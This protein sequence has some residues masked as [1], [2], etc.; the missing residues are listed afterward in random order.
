M[1]RWDEI[2]VQDVDDAELTLYPVPHLVESQDSSDDEEDEGFHSIKM[3]DGEEEEEVVVFEDLTATPK[4][5][6]TWGEEIYLQ[7]GVGRDDNNTSSYYCH[8]ERERKVTLVLSSKDDNGQFVREPKT[9]GWCL[10]HD[11]EEVKP[12]VWAKSWYFTFLYGEN[13]GRKVW[14]DTQCRRIVKERGGRAIELE[15]NE[16]DKAMT[17]KE[18]ARRDFQRGQYNSA[19]ENYQKAEEIIGG[20]AKGLY[21]VANQR[22]ELVK[23]LSNQAECCLRLNKFDVALIKASSALQL[24]GKH[25]KSLLRRAKAIILGQKDEVPNFQHTINVSM[26]LIDVQFVIDRHEEG[27]EEATHLRDILCAL[28]GLK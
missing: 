14:M 22:G 7:E 17:F 6:A 12:G 28:Q 11:C 3:N 8:D 27:R 5:W 2:S 13:E 26:A 19:L 16:M 24:D 18:K 10:D 25:I 4:S 23:I 15:Y 1:E 21:L 20:H 9:L